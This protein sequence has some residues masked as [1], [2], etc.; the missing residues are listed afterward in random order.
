[1]TTSA[2]LVR[3]TA[4]SVAINAALSAG[5]CWL[6]FGG[7][8]T[9]PVWGVTGLVADY[10]PQAFMIGLM[11]SLV[12]GL[13]TRRAR[14]TGRVGTADAGP[15]GAIVRRAIGFACASVG[16]ALAVSATG[17]AASGMTTLPFATAL[18][19]KVSS[20]IVLALIVTPRAIRAALR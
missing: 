4:I 16:A 9:V 11:G 20:G 5:F 19:I 13:L 15:K 6:V 2:F 17:F 12:P 8:A 10:V 1:M 3:E 14:L 18:A 7:A